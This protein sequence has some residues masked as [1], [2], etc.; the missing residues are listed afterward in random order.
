V[1]Q[2]PRRPRAWDPGWELETPTTVRELLRQNPI[3]AVFAFLVVCALAIGLFAAENTF[4]L[5]GAVA[6]PLG[7][8]L[9]AAAW[10]LLMYG[11]AK[12]W[13]HDE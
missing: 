9:G 8:P 4:H 3:G 13:I 5:R 12:G 10:W 2:R 7:L 11:F 1:E 6:I